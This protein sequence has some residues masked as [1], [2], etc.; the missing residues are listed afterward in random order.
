MPQWFERLTGFLPMFRRTEDKH[1]RDC[2]DALCRHLGV[3][4][5]PDMLTLAVQLRAT[6]DDYDERLRAIRAAHKKQLKEQE[7]RIDGLL[8]RFSDVH[9]DRSGE[10]T[11][12][13]SLDFSPKMVD[14]MYGDTDTQRQILAEHFARRVH[15]EIRNLRF[16]EPTDPYSDARKRGAYCP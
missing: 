2:L 12:R 6:Q 10:D 15:D 5:V 3:D 13:V 11:F 7:G 8:E 16:L 1:F 4:P 9:W 14:R